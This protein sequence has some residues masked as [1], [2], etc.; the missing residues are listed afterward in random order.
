MRNK[1]ELLVIYPT[2]NC[3]A[4]CVFC[5]P[6]AGKQRAHQFPETLAKAD[7][8]KAINDAVELGLKRVVVTGGEPLLKPEL[9]LY[10]VDI[11]LSL[12]LNVSI[13]T[14]AILL[15][16]NRNFVARLLKILKGCKNDAVLQIAPTFLS[17]NKV[18]F[19]NLMGAAAYDAVVKSLKEFIHYA[20]VYRNLIVG[21]AITILKTN[22]DEAYDIGKYLLS[23]IGVHSIKFNPVVELGRFKKEVS[24]AGLSARDL[25]KLSNV[26]KK[27]S[28]E[29]PRRISTSLPM[30]LTY[31]L[32]PNFCPYDRIA[33]I[34][35][36]GRVSLC[37]NMV[38]K[39]DGNVDESM[40]A[41]NIKEQ[42][43]RDIYLRSEFFNFIR[44]VKERSLF[45][46][47]CSKCIFKTYCA[48]GCL[49]YAFRFYNDIQAPN[50]MCQRLFEENLFPRELIEV[51]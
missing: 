30:C 2:F 6:E 14:N 42:R 45:K 32:G 19:N 22:L 27:L 28:K 10:I 40:I 11:A 17:L 39:A 13:E 24:H 23:E 1:L 33:C 49:A 20:Q 38:L 25:I 26:V 36:D 18:K 35:P 46:G 47:I 48:P 34:L 16:S 21:C 50:P 44:N 37:I 7:V 15:Q 43:L 5:W 4:R 29:Y 31:E 3:N 9:T 12:G 41:G 8:R 51:I